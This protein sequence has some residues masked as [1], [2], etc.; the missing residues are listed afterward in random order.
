M[1]PVRANTDIFSA[2]DYNGLVNALLNVLKITNSQQLFGR[3]TQV[4]IGGS[5]VYL[6]Q[7]A[8]GSLIFYDAANPSGKKLQDLIGQAA[9]PWWIGPGIGVG[10]TLDPAG[11][12]TGEGIYLWPFR[13]IKTAVAIQVRDM[14]VSGGY[15]GYTVQA[16]LYSDA[17]EL[18]TSADYQTSTSEQTV[19]FGQMVTVLSTN[20]YWLAFRTAANIIVKGTTLVPSLIKGLAAGSGLPATITIPSS[21]LYSSGPGAPHFPG[22]LVGL[23]GGFTF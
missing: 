1:P 6:K 12:P 16:G 23:Q 14:G 4:R 19:S 15:A 9:D 2:A 3:P 18:L 10:G 22:L 8:D 7:A 11:N 17:G 20:R 5:T 21:W 13:P